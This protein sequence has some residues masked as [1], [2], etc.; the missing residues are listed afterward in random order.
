[1]CL[2]IRREWESGAFNLT[3]CKLL[4]C[5]F[6]GVAE[7]SNLRI[8]ECCPWHHHVVAKFLSLGVSDGFCRNHTLR[9]SDVSQLQL[10]GHIPNGINARNICPHAFINVNGTPVGKFHTGVFQTIPLNSW[11][12]ADGYHD[13]IS[14][15]SVRLETILGFHIYFH[16][17][18]PTQVTDCGGLVA[19]EQFDTKFLVL[20][21][22]FF[23][24]VGVFIRQYPIH[25]LHN[26]NG[27]A[28]VS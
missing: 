25:K 26:G 11:G 20:F 4:F 1:M 8:T 6:F 28:I 2:P 7:R 18:T 27:H 17:C 10:S 12:E 14:L 22:N 3:I 13:S 24:N 15:D 23:R 9:F 21:C 19:G 5:L 16:A